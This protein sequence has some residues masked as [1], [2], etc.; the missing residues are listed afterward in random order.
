MPWQSA[1]CRTRTLVGWGRSHQSK[2]RE[3]RGDQTHKRRLFR[4]AEEYEGV[5]VRVEEML[6]DRAVDRCALTF[7]IS[8]E[9]PAGGVGVRR[10]AAGE[11]KFQHGIPSPERRTTYRVAAIYNRV[12]V[13]AVVGSSYCRSAAGPHRTLLRDQEVI[14]GRYEYLR[15]ASNRMQP[16]CSLLES[17]RTPRSPASA[18]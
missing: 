1:S 13:S 16:L 14:G 4:I 5:T 3:A 15:S 10:A 8:P 17:F 18:G 11:P 12:G 6:D 2:G 7:D 9:S